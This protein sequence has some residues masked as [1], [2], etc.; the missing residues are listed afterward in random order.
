MSG[1]LLPPHVEPDV[2]PGPLPP[3]EGLPPL[4]PLI[5]NE[6]S[7]ARTAPGS[8]ATWPGWGWAIPLLLATATLALYFPHIC[9]VLFV[10][11]SGEYLTAA[12]TR[13]IAHPPG[14][15]LYVLLLGWWIHLPWQSPSDWQPALFGPAYGGNLF[16]TVAAALSVAGVGRL[17][18]QLSRHP[19]WALL[20]GLIWLATPTFFGQALIAEVYAFNA[21]LIVV[22]LLVLERVIEDTAPW[23][24]VA[25]SAVQGALLATH[26]MGLLWAPLTA[27]GAL[28]YRLKKPTSPSG[29]W[30]GAGFACLLFLS[31]YL[32]LPLRSIQEPWLD[33]GHPADWEGFWA[34][35]T[36]Q[37][38]QGNV[39]GYTEPGIGFIGH[40]RA[41]ANWTWMQFGWLLVPIG[42]GIVFALKRGGAWIIGLLV[43]LLCWTL[44][45]WFYFRQIPQSELPFLEVYYIP[46][47]LLLLLI[48]LSGLMPLLRFPV[49]IRLTGWQAAILA[50]LVVGLLGRNWPATVLAQSRAHSQIGSRFAVSALRSIPDRSLLVVE[51]DEIF[52]FWYLQAVAGLKPD[53][54][55]LETDILGDTTSWYWSDLR[56]RHPDLAIPAVPSDREFRKRLQRQPEEALTEA[57]R[58][59]WMARDLARSNADRAMFLSGLQ[60]DP[61][62]GDYGMNWYGLLFELKRGDNEKLRVQPFFD[63]ELNPPADLAWLAAQPSFDFYEARLKEKYLATLTL[64]GQQALGRGHL[65]EAERL[66]AFALQLD[67]EQWNVYRDLGKALLMRGA[68]EQ[69]GEVFTRLTAH[70]PND[71]LY[72]FA[73]AVVHFRLD[74]LRAARLE[75]AR[76]VALDPENKLVQREVDLL[77]AMLAEEA[78][79]NLFPA[80]PPSDQAGT[81][82][83]SP[84]APPDADSD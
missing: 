6:S 63:Q 83:G 38:Y 62:G 34:A 4:L 23:T 45:F 11:D 61:G 52:L 75:A 47:H 74:D 19:G 21:L 36:R 42:V 24:L 17:L 53:T 26:P 84:M 27:Y 25:L 78:V 15:P 69:A 33:W 50:V 37:N 54:A 18:W 22:F 60:I 73:L 58:L 5:P 44:P 57:D 14:Y 12:W 77:N 68:W 55:I 35:I 81:E 30:I 56:R 66:F 49:P 16:S 13:G 2:L 80:P 20:G 72:P 29:P 3:I 28:I 82:E 79:R 39:A 46:T 10:G 32:S 1:P 43:A 9:P 31:T 40:A 41:W 64:Y 67:E 71:P 70:D 7:T 59:G 76:A 51:G 48:G 8:F 65:A